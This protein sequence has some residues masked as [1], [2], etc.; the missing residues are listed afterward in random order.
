VSTDERR[1]LAIILG[2]LLLAT[3]ARWVQR[4]R[5]ILADATAVDLEALEEASR[6][7]RPPPRR[8]LKPGTRLDPNTATAQ[9]LEALPGVGPAMAGRIVEAREAGRFS[10]LDDLRRVKGIGP[11]VLAKLEPHVTLPP[12]SPAAA[13]G[14]AAPGSSRVESEARGS[15]AWAPSWRA[16]SSPAATPSA[17]SASGPKWTRWPA[18]VRPCC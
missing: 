8:T 16:G 17:A 4:P 5:P 2:L 3:A 14:A 6:A 18:S 11:G 13:A 7:A 10:T 9:E 15:A 1:A 12:G